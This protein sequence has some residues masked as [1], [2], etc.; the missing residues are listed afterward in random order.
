[1]LV[2]TPLILVNAKAATATTLTNLMTDL[3]ASTKSAIYN[4]SLNAPFSKES[5]GVR[6]DVSTE[7]GAVTVTNNILS[8]PGRNGMDLNLTLVYSNQ[9][10][11]LFDEGT[12]SPS[13][14][15]STGVT[16]IAFYEV[17]NSQGYWLRTD[18]LQYGATETT[19]QGT[20]TQGAETWVFNGY[21]QQPSATSLTKSASIVN[22]TRA[23][24]IG[25]SS[26]YAFGI[27]WS[28]SIP[29]LSID[30]NAI[31]VSLPNGQTYK[32]NTAS[33]SGLE[34][35]PLTDVHF[36]A[37]TSM[38]NGVN[39]SAYRLLRADG[40]VEY[41]T[42]YGELMLRTD[43]YGNQITYFWTD[44][45]GLRLLT[46]VID[47]AG[48]IVTFEYNDTGIYVKYDNKT[49]TL[50]KTAIPGYTGK[51][52]LS[53]YSDALGNTT[54]YS[55]SLDNAGFDIHGGTSVNNT[56]ANLN[57]IS[58]QTGCRTNYTFTTG[59]KNLAASGSMKYFKVLR[60]WD[61]VGSTEYNVQDYSYYNEPDG[62][63]L[64]RTTIDMN[65]KYGSTVINKD[66]ETVNYWYNYKHQ[67]SSL[68]NVITGVS[69]LKQFEYDINLNVP[70]KVMTTRTAG[71][72]SYT[73]SVDTYTYDIRGNLISENHP[74]DPS[75]LDGGEYVTSYTYD[76]QYNLMLTKTYKQDQ[77]TTV[78]I[79]NTLSADKKNVIQ[80]D[81]Y[82]EN[83][84]NRSVCYE[85]DACGNVTESAVMMTPTKWAIVK[86][87]YGDEYA[88]L[89]PT[90]VLYAQAGSPGS[91]NLVALKSFTYTYDFYT[92]KTLKVKD[93]NGNTTSYT[94]DALGRVLKETLPDGLFR[95]TVYDDKNNTLLTTDAA[96]ASLLYSYDP[97]GKLSSVVKVQTGETISAKTYDTRDNLS[98]DTDA[99]GNKT[100]Y[101]YD[102]L[103]RLISVIVT[104]KSGKTVSKKLV[105]YQ[106]N[107]DLY[108]I[109]YL[110][111][112]ETVVGDSKS[113]VTTYYYN[114]R[115]QLVLAGRV[116]GGA[117]QFMR[118]AYDYL[119]NTVLTTGYD[120]AKTAYTYN[121]LGNVLSMTDPNG[122]TTKYGYDY[123]GNQISVTNGLGNTTYTY[124]DGIGNVISKK[125][126]LGNGDYS[127]T[128]YYYDAAG[129][130]TKTEDAKGNIS[131]QFYNSRG[132][133]TGVEQVITPKS[134]SIAK[135]EYDSEGR[136]TAQYTGLSSWDDT[137]YSVTTYKYDT[138]GNKISEKDAAGKATTYKYDTNGN[139]TETTDRNGVTTYNKYDG[140]NRLIETYNSKDG[141]N[142]K[143]T[144]VYDLNGLLK[145]SGNA[146][147]TSSY[148]YDAY[149]RVTKI[150]YDNGCQ[151]VYTYDDA[152]RVTSLTVKQGSVTELVEAY[153]Y[154]AGG[155]RT[156][157]VYNGMRTVYTY[158]AA[159]QLLSE[160]NGLTGIITKYGYT[161]YSAMEWMRAYQ[162][163]EL[164]NDCEY[165]YDILGNQ[166]EKYEN[167][168][169]TTYRYD[170]LSRLTVA[171]LPDSTLQFYVFDDYSNISRMTSCKSHLISETYYHYDNA[172][173]LTL[174][175]EG[176][177]QS[178]YKYDSCGNMIYREDVIY[179]FGFSNSTDTDFSYNGFNQLF[180]V[181]AS[182]DRYDYTYDAEGMRIGKSSDSGK[183]GY[184]YENGNILIET[185][186]KGLVTAKNIWGTRLIAR[187]TQDETYSYLFDGHGDITALTDNLGN[188]L[189]DYAYD[190][191]GNELYNTSH[192]SGEFTRQAE[193]EDYDNPFRYCGE[194]LDD[195]TGFYY[196]RAR[197]YD[198]EIGR[199][200]S[201]DTYRGKATDTLSLNLYTYCQ[202]DPVNNIDP[203][204]HFLNVLFGAIAGFFI[205]GGVDLVGQLISNGFDFS[206]VDWE[207]V[208]AS[209][210]AGTVTGAM[211]GATGGGSL[212]A[213]T[214]G[215]A[216]GAGVGYA[217]YNLV[218]GNESTVQG[219][220]T[221]MAVGAF[222]AG[223]TAKIADVV[224]I[225]KRA[226]SPVQSNLPVVY[227][228][229]FAAQQILN[230]YT[231]ITPGGRTITVHAA[232]RMVYPTAGRV[233][234]TMQQIDDFL[235]YTTGIRK[236]TQ[237]PKG[238]TLTLRNSSSSLKEV[239]VDA[240]TGKRV[241]TVINPKRG[242]V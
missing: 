241:V 215:G 74:I 52:Y 70:T 171:I 57:M 231:N 76:S 225:P 122:I 4:T 60:R 44:T 62:Y 56:Y 87:T 47:S 163:G 16:I 233:P 25:D 42:Q 229:D 30:G 19:I 165:K 84:L 116:A 53:G 88:K 51:Y 169:V 41:F 184:L 228:E 12:S 54:S 167:G 210:A 115:E 200:V 191:Y 139:L 153:E 206:A 98:S 204:G 232:E 61:C 198:P 36:G 216:L 237:H 240:A 102:S 134:S 105:A 68:E 174:T 179:G 66:G 186:G 196:L 69:T 133:L 73:M 194:Y 160:T 154:D 20:V 118:Y 104:D 146:S 124:Y 43:R 77:D 120:G 193:E 96:G 142:K 89:Y 26:R 162:S 119:G 159:N 143:V 214:V 103:D 190:P 217:T 172:G 125:V 234:T 64:Y 185:D 212:V 188:V 205:G 45:N 63:P 199:F 182:G 239:V 220:V 130:L 187:E 117:E 110:K 235:N 168:D 80:S 218:S 46:K 227:D 181:D 223:V 164:I 14:S 21:Y 24:S 72:S 224:S 236:I 6:E 71:G 112:T 141:K 101:K 50:S 18:A 202:G 140:L 92:G 177:S 23:K 131:L 5:S 34:N 129:N 94:Y 27:G 81:T 201:E 221:E 114:G 37:D 67:L 11:K 135:M 65:Y 39:T 158:N 222:T 78:K 86:N 13:I 113:I 10:A 136:M 97:F 152:D 95:T 138:Y 90:S 170:A 127:V 150:Q 175:E 33:A 148:T 106:E 157:V 28:L 189:H 226:V 109:K 59:T 238:A 93:G 1:M 9:A 15:K 176:A 55:Y 219:L 197:F 83:V 211:A 40:S 149:G 29:S 31:Y 208:G 213:Q 111:V 145:K 107:Y 123:S 132:F 3:K 203:T 82:G 49:I 209:A 128:R 195:E 151:K 17:Y 147:Q 155:R 38:S 178:R 137:D 22:T 121:A 242:S 79:V 161:P 85:Y 230:S 183:T 192:S 173:R 144:Y 75:D 180:R 2:L 166:T 207:S 156:A 91:A 35:Y 100:T 7:T 58:Y 99:N 8:I 108:G 32:Y 126:P 48:R